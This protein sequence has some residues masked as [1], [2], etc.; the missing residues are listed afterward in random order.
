[1][2]KTSYVE[3][4]H[5][6]G[7]CVLRGMVTAEILD[8]IRDDVSKAF[9]RF[10]SDRNNLRVQFRRRVDDDELVVDRLDPIIDQSTILESVARGVFQ[11]TAT[12]L[13]GVTAVFDEL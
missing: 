2:L 8:P 7:F 6:N 13:L 3:D 1:M 4:Y 5:R 12:Q 10:E 9:Q 11:E